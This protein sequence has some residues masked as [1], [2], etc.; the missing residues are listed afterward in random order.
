VTA[1]FDFFT[2]VDDLKPPSEDA[3]AGMLGTV[4]FN[5]SCYY[6]Y[7]NIDLRQLL[8]NLGGDA[9]LMRG[10]LRAFL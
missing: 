7:A 1:D 10:A 2:A 6:R 8:G 9:E 5:S 4:E 3:G